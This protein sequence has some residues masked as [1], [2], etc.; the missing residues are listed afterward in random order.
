ME[1]VV[2]VLGKNT[3]RTCNSGKGHISNAKLRHT[4]EVAGKT[5][6]NLTVPMHAQKSY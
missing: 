2:I 1:F 4:C 5:F 3:Q 6:W